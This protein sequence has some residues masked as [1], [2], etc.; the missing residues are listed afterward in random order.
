MAT[1][2]DLQPFHGQLNATH[3]FFKRTPEIAE[4]Y[5]RHPRDVDILEGREIAITDNAFPWMLAPTIKQ[6]ILWSKNPLSVV[7]IESIIPPGTI[8]FKNSPACQSRPDIWH[9]HVF[10][11]SA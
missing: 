1:W 5:R 6:K 7:E 2:E 8:W 9:C 10:M 11:K 3:D 4:L